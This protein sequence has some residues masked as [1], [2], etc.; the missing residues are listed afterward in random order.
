[1]SRRL[2]AS[3]RHTDT[4]THSR[5]PPF[6]L[7]VLLCSH[8]KLDSTPAKATRSKERGITGM[9]AVGQIV[10]LR[11]GGGG[12]SPGVSLTIDTLP[13]PLPAQVSPERGFLGLTVFH[14]GHT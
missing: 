14:S 1:M 12:W 10:I 7:L 11:Q 2:R 3:A 8:G 9:V 4:S 13:H 6:P 5:D